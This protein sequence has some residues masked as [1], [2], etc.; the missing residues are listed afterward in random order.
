M[1]GAPPLEAT[2]LKKRW[3]RYLGRYELVGELARGGMGTVY[4]ARHAG[5]AGF[6]RLFAIKVM[7]PHLAAE[8]DFVDML[9]DEARIAARIHHPNV[10]SIVDLGTIDDIHYVVMEYV[11]GPSFGTLL[12]RTG[13]RIL[14]AHVVAVMIDA[15][16]GLHAAHTLQDDEGGE[17]HL[18][19]RDISPQN[20][21]VG[22]DGIGR[23]TDFGVAKAE[24]RISST[25]PGV[26]K[27]KLA[28]MAPE[29][30]K[31]GDNIDR[32]ADIWAAGVVLWVALTGR[33][34]FK[35][36]SDAATVLALLTKDIPP[37]STH[38]HK[39][40]AAF[41]EIVLRALNR[42]PG[43]RFESALEMA[44]ALRKV[45]AAS[46]HTCSKH[47]VAKWVG[48]VFGEELALRRQAIREA[49]ANRDEADRFSEAS[50]IGTLPALPSMSS[51]P[52][53]LPE[54]LS[55]PPGP[56]GTGSYARTL[57]ELNAGSA[58]SSSQA[59][60]PTLVPSS[61]KNRLW[62][63]IAVLGA[64]LVAAA[65]LLMRS[66][67]GPEEKAAASP[68]GLAASAVVPSPELAGATESATA[69]AGSTASQLGADTGAVA[70]ESAG[71]ERK[72]P[73]IRLHGVRPPVRRPVPAGAEAT[74]ETPASTEPPLKKPTPAAGTSPTLE[75]NP[76]IRR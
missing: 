49:A 58:S 43:Q 27:G 14:P 11:E 65:A 8:T 29:Q 67:S 18:V 39:P 40:P 76:Y 26:R 53:T 66:P 15:L 12:K 2:R 31:E 33:H 38:G 9:R 47:D 54:P 52:N 4:L 13:D 72:P 50:Q 24:T 20:I 30:I 69:S 73:R 68:S 71:S 22:A 21:L 34:L 36:E 57:V 3:R 59:G 41:D 46:G 74:K 7:H 37:P 35:G 25:R 6:Q 44:D 17:I 10:V 19:H 63:A 70:T 61:G 23:I 28:F 5:E 64:L 56:G 42:D 60:D 16:E 62:I 32:R 75:K 1:G 55:N 48:Q 45:A 51:S